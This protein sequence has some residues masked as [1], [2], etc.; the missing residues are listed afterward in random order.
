MTRNDIIKE[1][2]REGII[3]PNDPLYNGDTLC[4]FIGFDPNHPKATRGRGFLGVSVK[5]NTNED[6]KPINKLWGTGVNNNHT[7]N[8]EKIAGIP[9]L[10]KVFND[11]GLTFPIDG[12]EFQWNPTKSPAISGTSNPTLLKF[13]KSDKDCNN[14]ARYNVLGEVYQNSLCMDVQDCWVWIH[15]TDFDVRKTGNALSFILVICE[16]QADWYELKKLKNYLID[17][18]MLVK[19][20]YVKELDDKRR[21]EATKS[22]KAA[23]MSRNMSH[24]IGSH[25]MSYLKQKLGSITSIMSSDSEVLYNLFDGAKLNCS[26]IKADGDFCSLL[27]KTITENTND[28]TCGEDKAN[29]GIQLPFL[30]GTGRFIGYLQERQDYIATIATDYIPYGAPVNLKDAIYDELN[31]DLRHMRHKTGDNNRPMNILL[32]YIAKSEGLSRENMNNCRVEKEFVPRTKDGKMIGWELR[33]D[34]ERFKTKNDILFGFPMYTNE[35]AKPHVFGLQPD[36]MSSDDPALSEMRKVNFSLPGG[37]VGRQ[38]IFSIVENIIRNAA[39]H[40]NPRGTKPNDEGNLELTFD[41]I[42]ICDIDNVP[43]IKQRICDE[44][45]RNLYRNAVDREKLYLFTITDNLEYPENAK[46]FPNLEKALVEGYLDEKSG[47]MSTS[48]KGIK[49]IRISAAWIRGEVDEERYLKLNDQDDSIPPKMAPLVAIERTTKGHL[50]YMICIPQDRL[51]AVVTE[52]MDP[53]DIKMFEEM[54]SHS[55]KDWKLY[56]S[57]AKFKADNKI[58]YHYILV[59]NDDIYKKLRPSTSNRLFVWPKEKHEGLTTAWAEAERHNDAEK[60]YSAQKNAIFK[61][62]YQIGDNS[63]PIYIWDGTT[64]SNHETD[65]SLSQKIVLTSSDEKGA[66]DARYVYRTH[67]S[68]DN[69][70]KTYWEKKTKHNGT[71]S[72]IECIDAITGD[73]SSDRIVRREPLGDDWYYSHLYALKKKVAIFDERL[74]KIVHNIEETMFIGNSNYSD[75]LDTMITRVKNGEDLDQIIEETIGRKILEGSVAQKLY[76]QYTPEDLAAYMES[77]K[78]SFKPQSNK[79]YYKSIVYKE[80]GVDVFTIIKERDNTFAVIG[81][82]GAEVKDGE[83]FTKYDKIATITS[84]KNTFNIDIEFHKFIDEDGNEFDFANKYDYISIHQGILDKIYEGFGIKEGGTKEEREENNPKKCNVTNRMHEKFMLDTKTIKFADDD[85]S[86]NVFLPRF[87]IHS[88]RAKPTKEDMPQRLPFVQYA[89]IEHGVQDCK[90]A[91]VEL[92]DYARFEE[93]A[94]NL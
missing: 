91:L 82:V 32:N 51:V 25:V 58:S 7:T 73:N 17:Y 16:K 26:Q 75:E 67:H 15:I 85:T 18:I 37:L 48:N 83:T 72:A 94:E 88:G 21:A 45:W 52:D 14:S 61:T 68:N 64:A 3:K 38:A 69:D 20:R 11:A 55:A 2:C 8:P 24:N 46:L 35:N 71:Y 50:R 70:F 65:D 19:A 22:A 56:T 43:H 78:L 27:Q 81:F 31:P 36:C 4:D 12:I 92:L 66:T 80:K 41:V 84:S 89:A 30:V 9:A 47:N 62:V 39:K 5:T 79:N 13:F 60:K 6:L 33:P 57:V 87:I 59:A 1:F 77:T 53:D 28:N 76:D 54:N 34:K 90:Y 63:E 23:I 86:N 40:G 29:V 49:E 44:R 93:D 10:I 74:F 42:D